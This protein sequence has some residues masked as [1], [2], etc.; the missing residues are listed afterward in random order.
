MVT[1]AVKT[2]VREE[3]FSLLYENAF[4]LVAAFVSHRRGT[5]DDAKDIFQDALVIFYEKK[6]HETITI[7]VSDE[8]YILGIAKH[9]WSRKY[10]KDSSTVALDKIEAAITIPED[11]QIP[12]ANKLLRLLE[13]TGKKCMELL[14][15]FYYQKASPAKIASEFGYQNTHSASVQKFKCL[16]KIRTIVK[17]R[18]V[19]Y[20]DFTE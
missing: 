3:L 11:V 2:H 13:M 14:E 1:T 8:A 10:T 20:D 7:T 18:S 19:S 16:E 6:Q 9:L 5:F 17:E 15:A 12:D 4:P